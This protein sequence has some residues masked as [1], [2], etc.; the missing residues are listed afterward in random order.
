MH[1][2]D[3]SVI[4]GKQWKSEPENVKAEYKA[5]AEK[6][7]HKHAAE[8]PGYQYAPRK[9]S[10]KKRRTTARKLAQRRVMEVEKMSQTVPPIEILE[11]ANHDRS[12]V[13]DAVFDNDDDC[14]IIT[15]HPPS[16]SAVL[17]T[18]RP[19]NGD[20]LRPKSPS[21]M[22]IMLPTSHRTVQ[23]DLDTHISQIPPT[24]IMQFDLANGLPVTSTTA[25]HANNDQDFFNSL[26]DWEGIRADM[27]IIKESTSEELDELAGVELGTPCLTFSDEAQ[28]LEF[29]AELERILQ[30]FE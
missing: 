29:E 23:Q 11:A 13:E 21:S 8:N 7:K 18:D 17:G 15:S 24:R 12:E 9:S 6:M 4:L 30:L 19:S 1:N 10:G 2:N 5:L 16:A 22:S 20:E 26:I 3:I 14:E 25:P 27:D 28:R